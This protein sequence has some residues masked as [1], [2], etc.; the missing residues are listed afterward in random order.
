MPGVVV[1]EAIGELNEDWIPTLRIQRLRDAAG[2]VLYDTDD[3]AAWS[4]IEDAVN[5]VNL[6]YLDVLADVGG[7]QYTGSVT[8]DRPN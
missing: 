5:R 3:D 2:E 8:I 4:A 6:E 1:I 7:G